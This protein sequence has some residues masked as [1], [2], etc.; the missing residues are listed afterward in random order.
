MPR[1]RWQRDMDKASTPLPVSVPSPAVDA[2]WLKITLDPFMSGTCL[3]SNF[4]R[5]GR[6]RHDG[7]WV[8]FDKNRDT[9]GITN[10]VPSRDSIVFNAETFE[11]C[12]AYI[13]T[14]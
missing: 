8:V 2:P 3:I 9:R 1:R 6:T 7:R 14:Q 10:F 5:R 11:E 4:P 12:N 13:D